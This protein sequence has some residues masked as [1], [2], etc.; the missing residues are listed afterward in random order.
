MYNIYIYIVGIFVSEGVSFAYR[1]INH[2]IY[3]ICVPV[4]SMSH[5]LV[6]PPTRLIRIGIIMGYPTRYSQH[7]TPNKW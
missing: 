2:I 3:F 7:N 6:Q 1:Y 5:D 4:S